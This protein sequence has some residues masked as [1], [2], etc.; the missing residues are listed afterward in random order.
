M[1]ETP[2]SLGC[3]G[4]WLTLLPITWGVAAMA[5]SLLGRNV[6]VGGIPHH[7]TLMLVEMFCLLL[8]GSVFGFLL[9]QRKLTNLP[10]LTRAVAVPAIFF[11]YLMLGEV[12]RAK[13]PDDSVF[14][15]YG[16]NEGLDFLIGVAPFMALLGATLGGCLAVLL[17]R[18]GMPE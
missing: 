4:L 15:V 7:P 5:C 2:R 10:A 9:V 11:F 18:R 12:R 6:L 13:K 17:K 1:N 14:L 3:I 16:A 8:A